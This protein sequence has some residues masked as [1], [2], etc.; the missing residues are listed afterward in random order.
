MV[1]FTR[2]GEGRR[3]GDAM[4]CMVGVGETLKKGEREG[5]AEG[6]K[7]ESEGYKEA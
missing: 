4:E 3:D 6:A 7:M 1:H 2:T 5:G